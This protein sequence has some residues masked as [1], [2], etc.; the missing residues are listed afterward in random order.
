MTLTEQQLLDNWNLLIAEIEESITG[1]RKNKLIDLYK[2]LQDNMMYAPASG[3]EHYHNCFPGGYVDHVN[4]VVKC[5]R[6]IYN[7]W[8]DM[9]LAPD[10][11]TIEEL[12]FVALNHD[13]GKMGD[14]NHELYVANES[15]WHRKNQGK[16][17]KYNTDIKT[18]MGVP[19]RSLWILNQHG[20]QMSE[21]EF[22]GIKVHDGLYE[23]GNGQYL[24]PYSKDRNLSTALPLIVHQ[25]DLMASRIEYET[26]KSGPEVKATDTR[27]TKRTKQVSNANDSA[28]DLFNDIFG[29]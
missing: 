12:V 10:S 21:Q 27:K 19:D 23:E 14:L 7:T 22:I 25:A 18:Y 1:D 11:F 5:A 3:F 26:W 17:Y 15:E 16:I 20:I 6:N 9:G 2:N 13:L 4:R 28:K 24:K 8:L 29:A